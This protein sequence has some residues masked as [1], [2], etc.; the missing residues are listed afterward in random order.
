MS[1]PSDPS[2]LRTAIDDFLAERLQAKLDTTKDAEKQAELRAS[3][4]R[5]TW[6]A[7][8]ARRVNQIQQVTH[9][10][11]YTHP[12]ARGSSLNSAGNPAAGAHL[13]GSHSLQG[14][15]VP[16]VVG[17]AAALD[18]YKF[19]RLEV[20]G[21]TLLDLAVA[22]DP[23]LVAALS[24]DPGEA[25]GW[26]KAFA[27]LVEPKGNPASH[28]LAKQVYWP[29]D[30][31][32][33]HLL[34]PL[35]PSSLAHRVWTTVS[36]DRFGDAAKA[37]RAARRDHQAHPHGVREYPD[38]AVRN[39]GGTKPQN[40]SQLNSERRGENYLLAA[41]PPAWR[42]DP[43]R[44]PLRV[45]TIFGPWFGNRRRVRLLAEGLRKYL[46]SVRDPDRN[47]L[48][49]RQTRAEWVDAITTEL[50][51]FAAELHELPDGWSADPDCRLHPAERCWL[52]PRRGLT[53]MEFA[54]ARASTDWRN[55]ICERFGHWLNARL[56][57]DRTPM[58]E[59]EF[60]AWRGELDSHLRLLREDLDD[61]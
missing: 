1:S 28:A 47:N 56:N 17:N 2:R 32:D 36:E 51:Q 38:L 27:T 44:P 31:G 23:A 55:A 26:V 54:S 61:D 52:D 49:I 15:H 8:A 53:D 40:I 3:H 13:V 50:L 35:F 21:T 25:A 11:K 20:E 60:T 6:L 10:L 42:S 57:T 9:G 58:G 4:A 48:A 14:R 18:V 39:F 45:E 16:D 24:D 30:D 29:L 7:D 37:A 19:L 22:G 41:L 12:D 46:L 59:A 5:T 33:Y 34:A 43:V